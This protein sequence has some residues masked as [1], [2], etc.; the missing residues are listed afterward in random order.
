MA[1]AAAG[2]V[3]V[4]TPADSFQ[5]QLFRQLGEE[6]SGYWRGR[7]VRFRAVVDLDGAPSFARRVWEEISAAIPFGEVCS[8][9]W[10]AEKLGTRGYRAVGRA[11]GAN[12]LAV[13]IPCHRVLRTDG[14]LGGYTG[15]LRWKRELLALEGVRFLDRENRGRP[16][17]RREGE[18]GSRE[19]RQGPG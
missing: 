15:G 3:E 13:I 1:D 2:T 6:L 18:E 8:Y 11:L 12:P 10:L 9:K 4:L 5:V 14:G 16:T 19:S 7:P 17:G